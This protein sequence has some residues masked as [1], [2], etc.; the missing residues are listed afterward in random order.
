VA[1]VFP[2][3][4]EVSAGVAH[5]ANG[6]EWGMR[7][8]SP[9]VLRSEFITMLLSEEEKRAVAE[10]IKRAELT[11]SGEIVFALT[12]KSGRYPHADLQAAL[13][14]AIAA[15]AIYLAL[16]VPQSMGLLIWT[17]IIGFA[18]TLAVISH[19]PWRRWFISKKEMDECVQDSAFREFYASGLYQTRESNGVLIY[20]SCF[21]RR[22][23]VLGDKGIHAKMGDP[24]WNE[25]RDRIIR[26]IRQGQAVQG[27]CAA[28]EICGQA[29]AR[30]FPRRP[31]DINELPD[32]VLDR[33]NR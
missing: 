9:Y 28:V 4:E 24:H 26:G 29:L 17:E 12:D 2:E 15:A 11:T 21:E 3:A 10:A 13:I 1:A 14:G 6:D 5:P 23:V 32:E 16:P 31:D 20:L 18:L 30:H 22:V 8:R 19:I 33:T 7:H 27:I 25:V